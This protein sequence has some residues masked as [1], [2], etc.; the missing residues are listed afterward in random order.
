MFLDTNILLTLNA[1][2]IMSS[3]PFSSDSDY[4]AHCISFRITKNDCI[5][6]VPSLFP[7]VRN[8][9]NYRDFRPILR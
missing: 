5:L 4:Y 3:D 6:K 9:Y 8:Y 7:C 2:S 1:L